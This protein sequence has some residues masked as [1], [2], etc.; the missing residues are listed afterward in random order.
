MPVVIKYI[1]ERNGVEKMTFITKAE[2]DA[3]DKLLDTAEALHAILNQTDLAGDEQQKEA[4]SM[5]LAENKDALLTALNPRKK[6]QAKA[7]KPVEAT[8]E[9]PQ[10][11]LAD[12]APRKPLP[13][14]V[15][16][17]D[18]DQ[19]YEEEEKTVLLDEDLI[20]DPETNDALESNAA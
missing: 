19:I 5:Y 20:A 14:L 9:S 2:A 15:I 17:T 1:V 10:L 18:E 8:D 16:E 4:L 11:E 13:D 3:Y 6:N 12:A 7:K